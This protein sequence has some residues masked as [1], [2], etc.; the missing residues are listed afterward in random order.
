MN[1]LLDAVKTVNISEE[2]DIFYPAV[3]RALLELKDTPMEMNS[4]LSPLTLPQLDALLR[5]IYRGL[6]PPP[7]ADEQMD[8]TFQTLLK[9]HAAVVEKS[10]IGSV[11]RYLCDRPSSKTF[12][13]EN[14]DN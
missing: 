6:E 2:E 1:V 12:A 3:V 8:K 7:K 13:G 5:C 14:D 11:V 4:V 9:W 10:G